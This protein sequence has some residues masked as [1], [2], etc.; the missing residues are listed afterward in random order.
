MT[1][2]L[3][4]YWDHDLIGQLIQNDH[5]EPNFKYAS[6]WLN[7]PQA[8]AISCSLPLQQKTFSRK[9]CRGFFEGILPEQHNRRKIC[10]ILGISPNNDFSLLEKI[11]GECAGAI[12]FIQPD[13]K[14]TYTDEKYRPITENELA[15]IL[16]K[17]PERPLL[18]G[19]VGVRLSLAGVQDKIAVYKVGDQIS[20]PLDGSP[21]THIIKPAITAY[22]GIIFNEAFCLQLANSI[23]IN[24]AKATL[25]HA[26]DI[27]YLLIERYDRNVTD[28]TQNKAII[29]RLHQEDFC[30]ALGIVSERKYQNEGGPSLA[31]C[32]TLVREYSEVP[33]VDLQQLINVVIFNFLIGNCDA[34]GKN[35]SFILDKECR[36][37]PFYDLLST[38]YYQE[39]SLKMAMKIGGEYSINNIKMDNFD[40]LA[41]D[42][43]FTQAA[44]RHR[45]LELIEAL[46][47]TLHNLQP[48]NHV[49]EKIAAMI[50]SRSNR[51]LQKGAQP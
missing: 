33:V 21:S 38:T 23:G 25:E 5:G 31:Q 20:I 17:L 45:T 39:L 19:E 12:S 9:E 7:N 46:S 44:V 30:Q 27:G 4:V 40:K 43:G 3:D 35:F 29:S 51:L 28:G 37:A 50:K 36:L 8:I 2:I 14:T 15:N 1:K 18:A 47:S 24:V 42:I 49:E 32:F 13:E 48:S 6:S 41:K 22:E 34:H 16:R 26:E 11:G 10:R